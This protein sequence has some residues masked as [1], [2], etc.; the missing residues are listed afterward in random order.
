M[1]L[2]KCPECGKEVSNKAHACPHCGFPIEEMAVE[3]VTKQ[4]IGEPIFTFQQTRGRSSSILAFV[5]LEIIIGVWVG[6]SF[7][8]MN[9]LI[10]AIVFGSC[11]EIAGIGGLIGDMINITKLNRMVGKSLYYSEENRTFY[12]T[13]WDN[14]DHAIKIE[15]ICQFDGPSSLRIVYRKEGLKFRQSAMLGCLK[16]ED[17][18]K[19]RKF[20]EGKI[21]EDEAIRNI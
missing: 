12:F 9:A 6:L 4:S 20:K 3:E 17:V 15:N 7:F 16:R 13:D 5:L 21:K 2:I 19:L 1:P 14:V 11:L 8:N 10:V 18:L